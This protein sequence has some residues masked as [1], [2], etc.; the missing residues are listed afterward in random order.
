MPRLRLSDTNDHLGARIETHASMGHPI[1]A[2]GRHR[3]AYL[4]STRACRGVLAAHPSNQRL[5]RL[6]PSHAH[7]TL[8]GLDPDLYTDA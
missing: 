2:S 3:T 7:P 5:G 1:A 4:Q 6:L 8:W